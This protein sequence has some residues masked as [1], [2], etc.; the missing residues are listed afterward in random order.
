MSLGS[1]L[2]IKLLSIHVVVLGMLMVFG[3]V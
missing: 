2:R 1:H 3:V